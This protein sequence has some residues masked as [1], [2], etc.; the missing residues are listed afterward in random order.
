MN[1]KATIF[2]TIGAFMVVTLIAGI[3]YFFFNNSVRAEI[4]TTFETID[5]ESNIDDLDFVLMS[6]LRTKE[7]D[8]TILD[9]L[10]MDDQIGKDRV[11]EVFSD[12]CLGIE[13]CYWEFKF[14]NFRVGS[15]VNKLNINPDEI[16]ETK[17][18]IKVKVPGIQRDKEFVLKHYVDYP[19]SIRN[20]PSFL[21]IKLRLK[22]E[23]A[24][25]C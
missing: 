5:A 12:L 4:D 1:K 22:Q 23:G 9:H 3:F 16:Y 10:L 18:V 11:R 19:M 8:F 14:E 2:G 20:T 6:L 24:K 21:A 13:E 15:C 25:V 7:G 17:R